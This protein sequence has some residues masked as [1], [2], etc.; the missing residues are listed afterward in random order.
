[1]EQKIKHLTSLVTQL[2][3]QLLTTQQSQETLIQQTVATS[4]KEHQERLTTKY[5]SLL[6]SA[7]THWTNLTASVKQYLPP[8][9]TGQ[10]TLSPPTAPTHARPPDTTPARVQ[11][12][13]RYSHDT[14][15]SVRRSLTNS[16]TP[17]PA[18]DPLTQASVDS[19]SIPE[20]CHE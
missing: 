15:N 16:T 3:Q 10:S 20:T 5:E 19:F 4:M 7:N 9:S 8:V 11:K 6:E 17:T 14:L 13:S 2:Q 1:M 18:P 12:L